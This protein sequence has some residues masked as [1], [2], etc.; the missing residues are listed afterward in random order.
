MCVCT[1]MLAETDFWK[2]I[3]RCFRPD[4]RNRTGNVRM[5]PVEDVC[6]AAGLLQTWDA[7]P[8]ISPF[9]SGDPLVTTPQD[10]LLSTRPRAESSVTGVNTARAG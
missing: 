8:S 1:P 9:D 7:V 10:A 2:V 3:G 4:G 5:A 6:S